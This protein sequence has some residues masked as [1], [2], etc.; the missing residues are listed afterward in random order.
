MPLSVIYMEDTF[1]N[2]NIESSAFFMDKSKW[3]RFT[4]TP[5]RKVM[6]V[7]NYRPYFEGIAF[8][9]KNHI[10][11]LPVGADDIEQAKAALKKEYPDTSWLDVEWSICKKDE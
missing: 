5:G 4:V 11:E 9:R 1:R 3:I 10:E 2:G 7:M 6:Q 8:G